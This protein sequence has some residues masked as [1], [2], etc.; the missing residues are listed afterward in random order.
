MIADLFH[1]DRKKIAFLG[2]K[3]NS[4]N[5]R[6]LYINKIKK[7]IPHENTKLFDVI[8]RTV[9]YFKFKKFALDQSQFKFD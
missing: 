1:Y 3:N 7:Y 8:S 2:K 6:K 9:D 5:S 4:V